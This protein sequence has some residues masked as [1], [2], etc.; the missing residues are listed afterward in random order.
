MGGFGVRN[1]RKGLEMGSF[2]W[3][4]GVFVGFWAVLEA[5]NWG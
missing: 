4:S 3:N 5:G 1:G 2:G